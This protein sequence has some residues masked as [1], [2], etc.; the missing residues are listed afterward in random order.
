MEHLATLAGHL[1]PVSAV[2]VAA[3]G[4]TVATGGFDGQVRL[5]EAA[6]GKLL[7]AFSGVP[8]QP[9]VAANP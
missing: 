8:L 4:Q 7:K 6:T 5:Y 9:A 2:A 1:G 3:D